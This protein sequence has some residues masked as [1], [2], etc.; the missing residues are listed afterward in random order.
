MERER[1]S[2]DINRRQAMIAAGLAALAAARPQ[3]A[4]AQAPA[5]GKFLDAHELATLDELAELIIPAD[6]QSGG[7][8]AA[9]CALFIDAGLAE[10]R[11]PA[12]Q[13][14]WKDDIAEIDTVCAQMFGKVL[15]E[16]SPA[17][18]QAL[19]QRISRNEKHPV[20]NVET[21]FATIKWWVAEAYYTSKIG[22]HDELQYQGN[23]YIGEFLGTD[24]SQKS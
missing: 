21:S 18:R 12:W 24:V 4:F 20:E 15:L 1:M 6:A 13:Q 9:R 14:S 2:G 17:Q 10:S 11:D 23:V 16:A 5:A 8:R 19:M 22:I 7:A 3:G